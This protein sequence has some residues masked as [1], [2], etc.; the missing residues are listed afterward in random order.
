MA[1]IVALRTQIEVARSIGTGDY[2]AAIKSLR[3]SLRE[4]PED[5]P[6]LEM[7]ARCH[8]WRGEHSEAMDAARKALE[9]DARSFEASRLLG[10]LHAERGEHEIAIG[11][12]RNALSN[13]PQDP[14]AFPRYLLC[15]LH[16]LSWIVPKLRQIEESAQQDLSRPNPELRDWYSWANEYVAWHEGTGGGKHAPI[17]PPAPRTSPELDRE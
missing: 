3:Q 8:R 15:V 14:P 5:V 16:A 11:F 1:L 12:V 2:R 9:Y 13:L 17:L 6:A 4:S 10:E 7:I